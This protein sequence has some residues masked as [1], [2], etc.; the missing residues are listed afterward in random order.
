[1]ASEYSVITNPTLN[2]FIS[3]SVTSFGSERRFQKDL[4]V[5][6]LKGKLEL[7][8]GASAASMILDVFNKDNQ[9]V[10]KLDNDDALLGSYPVDDG[11]R[12]HVTDKSHKVG[13][14][15]D[16]SK[17]EKFEISKEEYEKR[18]D[19]VLAY[20]KRM[21][22]GQFREIDPEEKAK[23]EEEKQRKEQEEKEKAESIKVGDRCEV[24]IPNQISRRG[25]VKYVGVTDF[26]PGYWVGVHYD[27]PYGKNDGSVQGKRYFECPPK[28]GSFVKPADVETG[29]FPELDLD[30]EMDEL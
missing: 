27:E 26:K 24:R 29:D 14:F 20:K 15:E 11:M 1:M 5:A 4:T 16:V 12:I 2:V 28:Y 19:S 3:S 6:A 18:S 25:T 8:C 10:C 17:V 7:I 21:K 22:M 30:D 9:H 23:M 13:E